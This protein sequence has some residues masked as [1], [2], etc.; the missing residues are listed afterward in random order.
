WIEIEGNG[1]PGAL[2]LFRRERPW[3][4]FRIQDRPLCRVRSG[5]KGWI[6]TVTSGVLQ[7]SFHGRAVLVHR[8]QESW[9]QVLLT[10]DPRSGIPAWPDFLAYGFYLARR[11]D[12]GEI[13]RGGLL[14]GDFLHRLGLLIR[15]LDLL[16]GVP[17]L[18]D[19]VDQRVDRLLGRRR[20]LGLR[21]LG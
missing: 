20:G 19:V 18:E 11:H 7:L 9:N 5:A 3:L 17:V 15:R 1:A 13:R 10:L 14:A 8:H 21:R 4:A 16:G 2:I 12:V 6:A